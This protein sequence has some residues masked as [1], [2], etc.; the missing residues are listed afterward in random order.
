MKKKILLLPAVCL[1]AGL[2]FFSCSTKQDKVEN[3]AEDVVKA[4]EKLE[5][6]KANV[7]ESNYEEWNKF[8]SDYEDRMAKYDREI[9]DHRDEIRKLN[10]KRKQER[11]DAI[12][13]KRRELDERM[14]KYEN[15]DKDRSRWQS[16]KAEFNHDMNE[17][18]HSI[19]D[20][21]KDNEK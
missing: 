19:K 15:S 7:E 8:K 21:F 11:L 1:S 13:E 14:E 3:A 4:Q 2:S 5:D 18:G 12:E 16:F 10:D 6:A 17:L 9:E 20:L